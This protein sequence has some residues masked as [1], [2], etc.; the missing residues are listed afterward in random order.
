MDEYKR[1]LLQEEMQSWPRDS[2][3]RFLP[4]NVPLSEEAEMRLITAQ[5]AR[6]RRLE[7]L[8]RLDLRDRLHE[9]RGSEE[10]KMSP[11]MGFLVVIGAILVA[12]WLIGIIARGYLTDSLNF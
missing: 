10:V 2:K 8:E 11:L 4:H 5:V 1:E 6:K 12:W 7:E 9:L 3:G